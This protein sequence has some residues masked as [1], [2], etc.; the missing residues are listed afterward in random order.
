MRKYTLFLSIDGSFTLML[1]KTVVIGQVVVAHKH[2]LLL[3][4]TG[5]IIYH[6]PQYYRNITYLSI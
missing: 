3:F 5:I 6:L 4:R 1:N 2:H